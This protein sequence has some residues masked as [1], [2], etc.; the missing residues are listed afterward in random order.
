MEMKRM[1][2]QQ[3]QMQAE[4]NQDLHQQSLIEIIEEKEKPATV[5]YPSYAVIQNPLAD[6]I[7][8]IEMDEDKCL[9]DKLLEASPEVASPS[10]NL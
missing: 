1:I 10:D 5:E 2:D 7:D 6:S 3:K 9:A 8:H 4:L